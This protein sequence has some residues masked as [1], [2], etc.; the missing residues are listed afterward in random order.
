[1]DDAHLI[2][3]PEYAPFL[4]DLKERIRTAQLRAAVSVNRELV[5]LYWS[6]GKRI[7]AAQETQGWGA[8]VID[9]LST[10]LRS[11]FSKMAG[12]SSRNLWRMRAFA[13]AY[14]GEI[15]P[16]AVAEIPW[17]HNVI[18]LEKSKNVEERLWYARQT[19]EYGW[20]R[21]VLTHHISTQ[22][23]AREGKAVTNFE[24]TLPPPQSD[25]AR[26]ITKDPYNFEFLTLQKDAEERALEKGLITHIQRFLLELGTGFAFVGSQYPLEVGGEDFFIDLLFYHL[27]LR[28]YVVIELKTGKFKPEYAGKMNFYLAAVDDLLRHPDDA[29]SIGL[30]LCKEKKQIVVE[31]SLRNTATPIGVAGYRITETLPDTLKASLPTIEEIEQELSGIPDHE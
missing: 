30:I 25:L 16:Q 5:L 4:E 1:M 13:Q 3:P 18:L 23:H 15:L 11:E 28:C 22:L 21:N 24:R 12:F 27:K 19:V 29:P 7:L 9:R 6:I 31:Y 8:N 17:G 14:D 2:I 26:Q 20:S 10:D